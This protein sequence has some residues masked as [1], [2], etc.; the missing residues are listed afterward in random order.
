MRV[1]KL[2]MPLPSY[3][4]S[5][6]TKMVCIAV[7]CSRTRAVSIRFYAV[8]RER[9][10]FTAHGAI[11]KPRCR[12]AF[13]ARLLSFQEVP[14]NLFQGKFKGSGRKLILL[15]VNRCLFKKVEWI[16]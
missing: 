8:A 2:I 12:Y 1:L 5:A 3:L 4:I 14:F 11:V 16:R 15:S 6:S 9:S 13:D 10:G 7:R